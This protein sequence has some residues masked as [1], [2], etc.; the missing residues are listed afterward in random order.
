MHLGKEEE[1]STLLFYSTGSSGVSLGAVRPGQLVTPVE[2][3]GPGMI[4]RARL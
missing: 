1:Q 3:Q 4:S 2:G